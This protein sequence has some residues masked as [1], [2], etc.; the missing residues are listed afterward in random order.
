MST[1][2]LD[3]AGLIA[4]WNEN[5]Q[6]H[7]PATAAIEMLSRTSV[8]LVTTTYVL[9]ECANAVARR[10][11]RDRVVRLREDLRLAGDLFEPTAIEVERA[12]DEYARSAAG[13]A[14]IVDLIS[15]AVMRRLGIRQIFTNDKHFAAAGFE[16]LF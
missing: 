6:W 5:D 7:E 13:S 8:R 2:L 10:H 15:M 11:H 9:L 12:W 16:V 1:V 14:G 3:T 4:L